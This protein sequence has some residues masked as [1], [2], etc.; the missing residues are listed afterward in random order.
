MPQ[1]WLGSDSSIEEINRLIHVL[2]KS[3]A[4]QGDFDD[5]YDDFIKCI[6]SEMLSK[7]PYRTFRIC[8]GFSN[9]PRR[10]KKPWWNMEL[11]Q[12]WN[13]VCKAEDIYVKADHRNRKQMRHEYV[14]KRK[15]FDKKVQQN[16]R[17]YW[18]KMQEDLTNSCDN[19]KEFWR[20][21]GKIG[22]G[23]ERQ[24]KI[25]MEV[26]LSDGSISTDNKIVLDKWKSEF[27]TL[28]NSDNILS[29][30]CE[31]SSGPNIVVDDFL[32]CDISTDEVFHVVKLV[33]TGKSPGVDELP[34]ELLKNKTA[35]SALVRVFSVCYTNGKVPSL[36]S[37][38]VISPIPKS[39]TSD[40]RDP[41]SYRGITLAP[42]SYKLF[43][44]ILDFRL[45]EKLDITGVLHDEQNGF[46]RNR[47][48][49]DHLSTLLRLVN[50][51]N[52]LLLPHL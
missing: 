49:I 44:G 27:A 5:M 36:W 11:T 33:K 10:C 45:R 28:L 8:D 6:K 23:A 48:T 16:K 41:L 50:Y 21:I 1:D 30:E 14:Q 17:R 42:A 34:V 18:Y 24:R 4:N 3:E 15:A 13:T 20:K 25:P 19:P 52:C 9:K 2:E 12:M 7:L 39:S 29:E 31:N 40:P 22:V 26:I 35:L 51:V 37:K 43:C 32:D 47:N 46:R 38:G